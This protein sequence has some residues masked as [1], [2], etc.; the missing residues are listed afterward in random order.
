MW[1]GDVM[2]GRCLK[3]G[4]VEMVMVL[5][6]GSVVTSQS[7]QHRRRIIGFSAPLLRICA[8]AVVLIQV[9]L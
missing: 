6:S 4:K 1:P 8:D 7:V 3:D 5:A 9:G 2:R